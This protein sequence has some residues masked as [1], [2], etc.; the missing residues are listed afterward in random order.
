MSSL[1]TVTVLLLELSLSCAGLVAASLTASSIAQSSQ[2]AG[3]LNT[4]SVKLALSSVT[5]LDR[6]N[7]GETKT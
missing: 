6:G 7:D 1:S 5:L 3:D 2:V 4:L